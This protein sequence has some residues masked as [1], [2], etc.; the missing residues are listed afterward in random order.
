MTEFVGFLRDRL[1]E[2]RIRYIGVGVGKDS[3]E[4]LQAM[5]ERLQVETAAKQGMLELISGYTG[6]QLEGNAANRMIDELLGYLALPYADHPD[7]R[8]EWR[9]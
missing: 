4:E 6:V 8:D 2:D 1:A 3:T 7:Y 5:R 9:P